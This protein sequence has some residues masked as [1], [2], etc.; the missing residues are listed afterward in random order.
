MKVLVVYDTVSPN[1]N[2]EKVANAM[3]EVLRERGFEVD[4]PHV[5]SVDLANVKNYDCVLAGSPTMA[6]SATIPIKEFLEGFAQRA[7]AGKFAAAF[8]TRVLSRLSGAAAKGIQSRLE[9]LGFKILLPPL[10]A[11]VEGSTAKNDFALRSGE[12]DKAKKY[13]EDIAKAIQA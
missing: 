8:D 2:T 5:S 9:K 7:F 4:C 3:S 6:W 11:Y 12:L 13:A 10:A 1:R